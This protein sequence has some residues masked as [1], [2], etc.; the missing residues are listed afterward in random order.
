M[1]QKPA[2]LCPHLTGCVESVYKYYSD[3]HPTRE[4]EREGKKEERERGRE[5]KRWR[6]VKPEGE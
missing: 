6:E 2:Q 4:G 3:L 1:V 5:R